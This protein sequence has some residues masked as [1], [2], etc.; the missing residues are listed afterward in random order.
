MIVSAAGFTLI[1]ALSSLDEPI[2][3]ASRSDRSEGSECQIGTNNNFAKEPMN[4][5]RF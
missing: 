1:A 4:V 2:K 3:T 5:R